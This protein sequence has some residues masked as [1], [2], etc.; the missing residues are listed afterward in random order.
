MV[1]ADKDWKQM[2]PVHYCEMARC[3]G[4]HVSV[5][6][7]L[8][9][10]LSRDPTS[11]LLSRHPE[12]LKVS[13]RYLNACAHSS[14]ITIAKRWEHPKHLLTY[15]CMNNSVWLYNKKIQAHITKKKDCILSKALQVQKDKNCVIPLI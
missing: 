3:C 4:K 6:K 5:H 8:K 11:P 7:Q 14:I 10:K 15:K 13:K 1:S 9:V 12:E 2:S